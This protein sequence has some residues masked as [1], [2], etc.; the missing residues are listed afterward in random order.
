MELLVSKKLLA[1]AVALAKIA[2]STLSQHLNSLDHAL[3]RV[4]SGT[5]RFTATNDTLGTDVTVKL[6]QEVLELVDDPVS[7]LIKPGA[8]LDLV[9]QDQGDVSKLLLDIRRK[10]LSAKLGGANLHLPIKDS[11]DWPEIDSR[12]GVEEEEIPLSVSLLKELVVFNK[13]FLA[14]SQDPSKNILEIRDQMGIS[15]DRTKFGFFIAP[16]L[17][18]LDV[19]FPGDQLAVLEQ[20]LGH[21]PATI[22]LG[23]SP[24]YTTIRGTDSDFQ[25]IFGL[26]KTAYSLGTNLDSVPSYVESETITLDKKALL[27]NLVR[28]ATVSNKLDPRIKLAFSG[29]GASAKMRLSTENE[30]NQEST[31]TMDIDRKTG[32]FAV[33]VTVIVTLGGLIKLLRMAT[34]DSVLLRMESKSPTYLKIFDN[35]GHAYTLGVFQSLQSLRA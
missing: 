19:R 17:G 14:N 22:L 24:A 16:A 10:S 32:D 8:L 23:S 15:T 35:R 29:S 5:I 12:F 25:A 4:T 20:A 31:D 21:F 34:T 2:A 33:P 13:F 6:G 28:L 7:F 1:H 27:A 18:D 26:A 30:L 9:N 11:Q 3:V